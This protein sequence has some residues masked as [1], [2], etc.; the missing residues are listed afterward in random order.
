MYEK[1]QGVPQDNGAAPVAACAVSADLPARLRLPHKE[2][3]T[4]ITSI[5][6]V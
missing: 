3:V 6:R 1:G 4:R 2:N 5:G